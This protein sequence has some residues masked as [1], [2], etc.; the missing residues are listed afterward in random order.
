MTLVEVTIA[1]A[2]TAMISGGL[3]AVGLEARKLTEHNRVATEARSLA[4]ER[5]EEMISVGS[6]NLAKPTCMLANADT[7]QS[8]HGY[9][10]VRQPRVVWHAVDGSVVATSNA[11]YAEVHVDVSYESRI[12]KGQISDTYS[13]IL[14]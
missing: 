14:Q 4:K 11:V 9:T 6:L 3:Y 12:T 5:L 10:I 13:T 7:N 8:L 1:M 2:L